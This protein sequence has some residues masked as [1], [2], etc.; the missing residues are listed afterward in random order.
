MLEKLVCQPLRDPSSFLL[1][2]L[3]EFQCVSSALVV[4]CPSA[5]DCTQWLKKTQQAQG[6][7]VYQMT[8]YTWKSFINHFSDVPVSS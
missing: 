1:I 4:H 8:V 6:D 7:G 3:T 5:A 2:H